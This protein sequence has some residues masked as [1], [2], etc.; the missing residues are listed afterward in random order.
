MVNMQVR[1]NSFFDFLSFNRDR[2][3]M[4]RLK[5]P[6]G[7]GEWKGAWSDGSSEWRQVPKG[8]RERMGLNFDDDG[9]FWMEFGDFL[10]YFNEVSICRTINTTFKLLRKTWSESVVFGGWSRALDRAGGCVNFRETFCNNP[11]YM[12]EINSNSDSKSDEVLINMDQLSQRYLGKDNLTMGFFIMRVEENRRYRLHRVKPKVLSSTYTN[13][14]S[15]FLRDRLKN[16][17]YVIIPSTFEPNVEGQFLLRIYSDESNNLTELVKDS[18]KP[19]CA[20]C[21]PFSKYATCATS[22]MVKTARNLVDSNSKSGLDTYVKIKC[23]GEHVASKVVRYNLHPEYNTSAIFYRKN[24]K[25][26]IKIEVSFCEIL[27]FVQIFCLFTSEFSKFM[28][29]INSKSYRN[30]F[31][32]KLY[33]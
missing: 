11:Q 10:N 31:R 27:D 8:E 15:V 29:N 14:R 7:N 6:W 4:I 19:F 9:E 17:R 26:P 5:N 30:S 16:G 13:T 24:Q 32:K 21:N 33:V 3:Q 22:I 2:L 23:Q 25:K 1:G 20:P 12:F 28:Q 18:P